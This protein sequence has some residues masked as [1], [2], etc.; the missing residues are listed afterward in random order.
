[1]EIGES[2]VPAPFFAMS[3]CRMSV[4]VMLFGSHFVPSND[5]CN[6]GFVCLFTPTDLTGMPNWTPL[7]ILLFSL[8]IAFI[9]QPL[10]SN[11]VFN[12]PASKLAFASTPQR[13]LLLTAHPDDEALFFA[14]TII[15]LV[16][17]AKAIDAKRKTDAKA[18]LSQTP[19]PSALEI[20]SLCLSV[21]NAD[22][23]GEVRSKEL[24]RSLDILD[25]GPDH[26]WIVDHP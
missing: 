12:V 5:L 10:T 6:K 11:N 3:I 14:P 2:L 16:A 21:G 19:V 4:S 23:L 1:M 8:A 22:G 7:Y 15:S 18:Q 13:I 9:Y 25:I 20:Y 17:Q 26:S 24:R